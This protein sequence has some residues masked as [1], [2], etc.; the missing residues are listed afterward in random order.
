METKCPMCGVESADGDTCDDC[1]KN[2]HMMSLG[3]YPCG[4]CGAMVDGTN[5][6]DDCESCE[7]A[8]EREI[9]R[10]APLRKLSMCGVCRGFGYTEDYEYTS[11]C[12]F[13][14]GMGYF[15]IG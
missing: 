6:Y 8:L 13:C 5:D 2:R 11:G 14:K 12:R 10:C 3:K 1:H 9:E 4:T 7:Q 15:P